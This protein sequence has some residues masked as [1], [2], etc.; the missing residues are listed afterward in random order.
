MFLSEGS[1]S[2]VVQGWEF[3]IA[4]L[5]GAVGGGFKSEVRDIVARG[6]VVSTT[7]PASSA[8][9]RGAAPLAS[10]ARSAFGAASAAK[11]LAP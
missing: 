2:M 4:W 3:F 11:T 1:F 9:S 7:C 10:G 8:S 5:G 6:S